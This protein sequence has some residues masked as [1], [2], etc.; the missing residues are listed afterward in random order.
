MWALKIKST[1]LKMI[2]AEPH[3]DKIFVYII[4]SNIY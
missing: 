3:N 2:P 4:C 1:L